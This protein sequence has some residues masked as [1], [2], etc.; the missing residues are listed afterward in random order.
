MNKI[1]CLDKKDKP[2]DILWINC[3]ILMNKTIGYPYISSKDILAYPN[4]YPGIPVISN[5]DIRMYGYLWV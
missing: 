1:I 2:E 5:S 4:Y 3:M